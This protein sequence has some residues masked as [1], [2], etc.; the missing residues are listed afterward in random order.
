[1]SDFERLSRWLCTLKAKFL[2]HFEL[3]TF[4]CTGL[5]AFGITKSWVYFPLR[6]CN[7]EWKYAWGAMNLKLNEMRLF[8]M[9]VCMVFFCCFSCLFVFVFF[10]SRSLLWWLSELFKWLSSFIQAVYPCLSVWQRFLLCFNLFNYIQIRV[11]NFRAIQ[12]LW[13]LLW[14]RR[15]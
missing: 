10:L 4:P 15:L 5:T 12:G 6:T 9:F 3:S 11:S 1:M 14:G 2:V 13:N 8:F 7:D